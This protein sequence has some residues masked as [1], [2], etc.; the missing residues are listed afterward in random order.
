MSF[1]RQAQSLLKQ[2]IENS[3]IMNSNDADLSKELLLKSFGISA[4]ASFE[5]TM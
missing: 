3:K 5:S 1:S 2:E 4:Q